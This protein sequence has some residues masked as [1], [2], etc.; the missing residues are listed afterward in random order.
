MNDPTQIR[1]ADYDYFL[2]E[3]RVAQFPLPERDGSRLLIYK[4][5]QVT[6]GL[7]SDI[8]QY[9]PSDTLL[10]FNDTRVIR[11][12]LIFHKETGAPIEIFCLEPMLP[13]S[14]LQSAFLQPS[15]TTWKC[16]IGNLKR[17]KSGS[18]E[19]EIIHEGKKYLFRV[20]KTATY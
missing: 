18:L 12:R 4:D 16:L 10:I 15:R 13:T 8:D 5:K 3:T 17:W 9:L 2:P 20:T 7:F 11:A 6:Q 14:E 19:R 1:I